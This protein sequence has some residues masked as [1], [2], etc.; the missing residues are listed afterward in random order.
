MTR[1]K[2][3]TSWDLIERRAV[4]G[5]ILEDDVICLTNG[6][7]CRRI[8]ALVEVD[9]KEQEMTFLSNQ[10]G[11]SADTIAGLCRARWEIELFFKQL[12][13]T[14]KLCDFVSCSANGIR[15]QIWTAL[16]VHLVMR[17][18]A[19]VGKWG[20]GFV[21]L[22]ALVRGVIWRNMDIMALPDRYGTGPASYRNLASPAAACFP[23]FA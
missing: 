2:E 1:S 13:Q 3:G 8:E 5:R 23:G 18:P 6:A 15:W 20:H 19:W 22:F 12:K 11:W 14:L 16:L 17:Y 4:K 9:G 10:M 7:R 21:R